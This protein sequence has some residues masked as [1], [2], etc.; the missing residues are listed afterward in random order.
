M[1]VSMAG[2]LAGSNA[3]AKSHSLVGS[4]DVTTYKSV[5][6]GESTSVPSPGKN[7]VSP[8]SSWNTSPGPG[9]PS[10]AEQEIV[11]KLTGFRH[12]KARDG[13]RERLKA[14]WTVNWTVLP[15]SEVQLTCP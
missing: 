1:V 5:P 12:A 15:L 9:S 10:A 7:C 3:S 6:R 4:I 2:R 13:K 8:I 14:F 11:V